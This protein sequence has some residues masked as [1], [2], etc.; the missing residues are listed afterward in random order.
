MFAPTVRLWLAAVA[1]KVTLPAD[2]TAALLNHH[3]GILAREIEAEGG[4]IDKFI[5]DALMAFWGAP[6]P[7][8]DH[9]AR[10][11]RAAR[12]VAQA[13]A[14][15]NAARRAAALAAIRIRVGVHSGPVVVG[16]IGAP[17][18]MNYTVVGDTVNTAERIEQLAAR[19]DDGAD[20]TIMVTHAAVQAARSEAGL[21]PAGVFDV[22]GRVGGV[23]VY[24]LVIGGQ[25]RDES[26]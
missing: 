25:G 5:G 16:N 3:F 17:K 14:R 11:L 10:A 20:A 15:D 21:S 8:P 4:T 2:Q 23:R 9:A 1:R 7:Q 26:A 18:R 19:F 24:R 13:L 12:G 6:D 22:K